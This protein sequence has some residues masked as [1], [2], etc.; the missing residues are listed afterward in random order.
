M[1]KTLFF[2]LITVFMVISFLSIKQFEYIQFQH[3][4][5]QNEKEKWNV[6]IEK[7][8]NDR[9]LA[10]QFRK[11]K[12]IA[13][14]AKINLQRISYEKDQS[15]Q[16]K[17]VYYVALGKPVEY[18][19]HLKLIRGKFLNSDSAISEYLSTDFVK[20]SNQVGQLEVFHSFN[21]IEIR[22]LEAASHVKTIEGVYSTSSLTDAKKFQR[23]AQTNN[24]TVEIS[25]EKGTFSV[26]E[27]P[28]QDMLYKTSFTLC[29]LVFLAALYD[30]MSRYKEVAV[31]NLF[32]ASFIEIGFY[33]LK[34]YSR[35]VFGAIVINT[36]ILL[37]YLYF[38]NSFQ[39]LSE[40]MIFWSK[41]MLYLFLPILM[42]FLVIWILTKTI[43]ISHMIK[44]KRPVKPFFY[45]NILA[46]VIIAVLLVLGLEQTISTFIDLKS[47]VDEN[48][49]WSLL[50]D[51]SILGAVAENDRDILKFYEKPNKDFE[52]LYQDLEN[53]GAIY[54][55]P[56]NYYSPDSLESTYSYSRWGEDGQ[57]VEINNNY[58]SI[59]PI[60][61]EN[62]QKVTLHKQHENDLQVLVP[63][64]YKKF[65]NEIKDTLAKDYEG[66]Y[67]NKG[68]K[69][70][71]VEIIYVK[72][73]QTY[74]SYAPNMTDNGGHEIVDPLAVIVD[75]DFNTQI[76][77]SN[78]SMGYGFYVKNK[79]AGSYAS[80]QEKLVEYGLEKI[81]MPTSIAYGIVELEVANSIDVLQ[82]TTLFSSLTILLVV[83]LLFFTVIYYLEI[84]KQLVALEWI[85]G[86][87]F[88]EKHGLFYLGIFAFWNFVFMFCFFGQSNHLLILNIIIS[89]MIIDMLL[90]SLIILV[91]EKKINKE[92]LLMK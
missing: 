25:K 58:L 85:F 10:N 15:G 31:R 19:K 68:V 16:E 46:R 66:V 49:K 91:K 13:V 92:V 52:K 14:K 78:I 30:V 63:V 54:I 4:N 8:E 79:Q 35:L 89:I 11:I 57:R 70:V 86:Y 5:D 6:S 50:K 84:N 27:Y 39:Q 87:S 43:N 32:G 90:A 23:I 9:E 47:T 22:P 33:L 2:L 81:W 38:Y 88:F 29:I 21:P 24:I 1:K 76:L 55:S 42:I 18:F 62:N 41:N 36:I 73:N 64:K 37:I 40:F 48:K 65:Q 69:S 61:N 51:Y 28:F 53:Q 72:N 82:I 20:N 80:T 77:S 26:T 44:N 71:N 67:S 17:T 45:L 60:F 59:N 56:S 83:L 75:Q 3:F 7:D 12:N 34:R 74:F